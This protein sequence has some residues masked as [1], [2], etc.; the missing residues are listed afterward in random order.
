M[1]PLPSCRGGG[2]GRRTGL[3]IRSGE[4][5]KNSQ[6]AHQTSNLGITSVLGKF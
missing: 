5:L 2:N 6:K 3:K 4:N 1:I